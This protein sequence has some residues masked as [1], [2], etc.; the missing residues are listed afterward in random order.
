M[1]SLTAG[2]AAIVAFARLRAGFRAAIALIFGVLAT[3]NGTL[4]LIHVTDGGP[5]GSDVTGIL[6]LGAG[7]VLAVLGLAI[8][9]VHRGEGART[10]TRRWISRGVFGIVGL[11]AF[12][13][14]LFPT[15]LA[16][17]DTHK[18]REP[19]GVPPRWDYETVSFAASD[20]LELSGWYRASRNGAA[21]VV[22]H[23]AGSDR[24]GAV[25]HAELL[26]RHGFGV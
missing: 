26:A 23:G 4:H 2:I 11:L 18:Y 22:V 3:V 8:P 12:Y 6:A 1:I 9:F 16:I 20:G 7:V 13:G 21:V 14:F 19:I 15:S 17:I 24:T 5:S 10:R 25:A